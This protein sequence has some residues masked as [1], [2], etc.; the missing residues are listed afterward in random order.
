MK[1]NIF[2]ILCV[3]LVLSFLPGDANADVNSVLYIQGPGG[4]VL[5]STALI[6]PETC[7]V[8]DSGGVSHSF[9][10][11][12]AICA[13]QTAK[14]NEIIASF[15]V[16][17]WGFGFSLDSINGIANAQDW[18]ELWQLW[19]NGTLSD[20]GIQGIVL[21]EGN[22]FQ[23]TYGPWIT[24]IIDIPENVSGGGIPAPVHS[25]L[26]VNTA[27][28]FL[29]SLQNKDGSFGTA[30]LLSDWAALALSSYSSP[31]TERA[32][33]TL[34]SYLLEDPSAGTLLT[35]YERRA[36]AL[37][38]LGVNPYSGTPT[39]YIQKIVEGFDGEQFGDLDLINDD[40]FALLVLA[41]A[42]Y[43]FSDAEIAKPVAFLLD[44]Q[45]SDGSFG[46]VD[47][48]AA[49]IQALALVSRVEGVSGSLV[50]ARG[51]LKEQQKNSG[52]FGNVY[53]TS[54][55]MQ[56]IATLGESE[57]S[58]INGE[59]TPG[60]YLYSQQAEDGGVEKEA[61]DSNRIWA[62]SYAIPATLGK[63]WGSILNTFEK[64][65][66]VLFPQEDLSTPLVTQQDTGVVVLTI[67]DIKEQ[68]VML[69]REVA[70]LRQFEY[71]QS[72]LDR[73][74][75]EVKAVQVRVVAFQIQQ[76]A[77]ELGQPGTDA[78]AKAPVSASPISQ[79]NPPAP[80]QDLS[81]ITLAPEGQ[82]APLTAEAKETV[83]AQ[84]LSPQLIILL[85]I[86]GGAVFVF[87]GGMN[88]LIPL[89]RKTFSKV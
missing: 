60:D 11:H 80:S 68:I 82:T 43:Q 1:N 89:L 28:S 31:E 39:N 4:S 7:S 22:N 56:A 49:A 79:V 78:L 64:P 5:A 27:I 42:G 53:A 69:Q 65:I 87:S 10:G 55:A 44:R 19:H 36:M 14:N 86:I 15:A 24:R 9:S 17:D 30:S 85:V 2:L 47:M 46:S 73:I 33:D 6:V 71:I 72:E 52:G 57:I 29:L 62:T 45:E 20:A 58:W 54:W 74:A 41:K 83:G 40:M 77:Q 70:V 16:T 84:G 3:V 38:A 23:L 35:D 21:S 67:E 75:L 18:S 34:R 88:A 50:N 32:K 8:Q 76:L 81:G 51:Y 63:S 61:A 12:K 13:L 66:V 59:Y 37:M 26:N 48:T 25:T